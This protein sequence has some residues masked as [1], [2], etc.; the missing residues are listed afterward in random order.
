MIFENLPIDLKFLIKSFIFSKCE[1]CY[2]IKTYWNLKSNIIFYEYITIFSDMWDD[3]YICN[4]NPI[5]FDKICI[6]C[7][8]YFTNSLYYTESKKLNI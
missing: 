6:Y 2:L 3:Y 1:Y 4:K 5:C 7:Y 8:E